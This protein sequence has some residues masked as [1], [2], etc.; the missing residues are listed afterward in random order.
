MYTPRIHAPLFRFTALV[1]AVGVA[2]SQP[3][4]S[5]CG[6]AAMQVD[7][8]DCQRTS[9]C[10]GREKL[11]ETTCRASCCAGAAS[12]RPAT[13]SLAD[14]QCAAAAFES[15]LAPASGSSIRLADFADGF[16][17]LDGL[18]LLA[19]SG[20]HGAAWATAFDRTAP[21]DPPGLRLHAQLCVWRI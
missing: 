10:G 8:C 5:P 6:C 13:D 11:T 1:A 18:P 17:A 14:C 7:A 9:C 16:S 21:D 3:M 2:F 15:P 4:L 20:L 19:N 12:E